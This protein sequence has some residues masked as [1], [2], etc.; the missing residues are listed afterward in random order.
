VALHFVAF[1]QHETHFD[2]GRVLLSFGGP[3]AADSL[4]GILAGGAFLALDLS[5]GGIVESQACLANFSFRPV[6]LLVETVLSLWRG[7]HF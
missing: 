5:R 6:G 2:T 1:H 3:G 4:P 7:G